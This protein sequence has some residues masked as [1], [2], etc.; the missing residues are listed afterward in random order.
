MRRYECGCRNLSVSAGRRR[1]DDPSDACDLG[2]DDIHQNRRR[3]NGLSPRY[4]DTDRSKRCHLLSK[5]RTIL[6]RIK[7]AVFFLL[8]MIAANVDK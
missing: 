5:D 2:R 8:L 7:P 6:R 3:V 4:I 1:H